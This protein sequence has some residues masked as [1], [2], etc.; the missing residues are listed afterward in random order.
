MKKK[1][2]FVAAA[3]LVLMGAVACNGKKSGE[4]EATMSEN[5][6]SL[7]DYVDELRGDLPFEL[8]EGGT[9]IMDIDYSKGN[10]NLVLNPHDSHYAEN[11]VGLF[12]N[13]E[14]YDYTKESLIATVLPAYLP[15]QFI[16]TMAAADANLIMS[17]VVDSTGR[18]TNVHIESEDIKTFVKTHLEE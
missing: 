6:A 5:E 15:G 3:A 1:L 11:V 16:S 17:F 18:C 4:N 9:V 13:P 12:D 7:I 10:V 2:L 14:D 8:E